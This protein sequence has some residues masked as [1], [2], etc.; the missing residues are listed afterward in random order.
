MREAK[1][2]NRL[3]VA[4]PDAPEVGRCPACGAEV[5]KRKRRTMDKTTTWYYRHKRGQGKDCPRRYRPVS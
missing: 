2:G 3:V 4:G 1:V 5:Q